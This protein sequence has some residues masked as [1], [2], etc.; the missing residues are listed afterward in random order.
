M[1]RLAQEDAQTDPRG[2]PLYILRP[3]DVLPGV[4]VASYY[5]RGVAVY[6]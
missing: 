3:E 1:R 4:D 6:E 2:A 5:S